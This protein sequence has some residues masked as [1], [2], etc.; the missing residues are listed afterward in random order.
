MA[1]L[2][3]GKGLAGEGQLLSRFFAAP[4]D[5]PPPPQPRELAGSTVVVQPAFGSGWI[6]QLAVRVN[7]RLFRS[8]HICATLFITLFG[9]VENGVSD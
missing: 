2:G 4:S 1:T 3:G 9:T 8:V 6:F 5:L 7:T